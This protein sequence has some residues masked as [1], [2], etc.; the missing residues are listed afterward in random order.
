MV[1]VKAKSIQM[2]RTKNCAIKRHEFKRLAYP[3]V[4]IVEFEIG[5][6][7]QSRRNQDCAKKKFQ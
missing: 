7:L 5:K 1:Y 2:L 6:Y 3:L 4:F